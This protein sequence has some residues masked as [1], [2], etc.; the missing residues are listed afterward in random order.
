MKHLDICDEQAIQAIVRGLRASAMGK[1]VSF[2][3][4]AGVNRHR[5]GDKV[6][7]VP[8]GTM[9]F[10]L[11]VNGGAVDVDVPTREAVPA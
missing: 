6:I 4:D 10:R 7:E 9:T 1:P 2:E 8:N 11:Y 5:E 3:F